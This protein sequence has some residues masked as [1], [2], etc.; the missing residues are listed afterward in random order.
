MALWTARR[1]HRGRSSPTTKATPLGE[2]WHLPGKDAGPAS[3]S[4]RLARSAR[5]RSGSRRSTRDGRP[6]VTDS[7]SFVGGRYCRYRPH[8]PAGEWRGVRA[9]YLP[10]RVVWRRRPP[11]A[12]TTGV[13][14]AMPASLRYYEEESTMDQQPRSSGLGHTALAHCRP[15]YE[16]VGDLESARP[17]IAARVREGRRLRPRRHAANVIMRYAAAG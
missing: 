11:S 8:L 6:V 5:I 14:M 16:Q 3:R 10:A 15:T 12:V 1:L 4:S 17:T 2:V 13:R 9:A 7:A